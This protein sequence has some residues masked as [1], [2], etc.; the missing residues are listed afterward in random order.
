MKCDDIVVGARRRG[1]PIGVPMWRVS[2]ENTSKHRQRPTRLSLTEYGMVRVSS[3][4]PTLKKTE[5]SV[6]NSTIAKM[7]LFAERMG[8]TETE[9]VAG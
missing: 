3:P 2:T 5:W 8:V 1:G 6:G 7:C 9:R 4:D